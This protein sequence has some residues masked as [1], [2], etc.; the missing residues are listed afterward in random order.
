MKAIVQSFMPRGFREKF[1]VELLPDFDQKKAWERVNAQASGLF[2]LFKEQ[3]GRQVQVLGTPMAKNLW[4][5]QSSPEEAETA[6]DL[7]PLTRLRLREAAHDTYRTDIRQ[8]GRRDVLFLEVPKEE[9]IFSTVERLVRLPY[10]GL[11]RHRHNNKIL[12]SSEC[13]AWQMENV[14]SMRLGLVHQRLCLVI[15]CRE[16]PSF[17]RPVKKAVGKPRSSKWLE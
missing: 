3:I 16:D 9:V 13:A 5:E 4:M 2:R 14:T 8:R 1:R 17:K 12:V 6:P 7:S 11:V 15:D 10:L